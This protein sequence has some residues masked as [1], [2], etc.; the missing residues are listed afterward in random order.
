M[1][2]AEVSNGSDILHKIA[3]IEKDVIDLKL[4]LLKRLAPAGKKVISVKGI[5]KGVKI[6]EQDITRAK[7]SLYG[8]T[9]L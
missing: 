8:K 6:S 1:K 7:K 4:A 9:G 2:Q 5:L 3:N